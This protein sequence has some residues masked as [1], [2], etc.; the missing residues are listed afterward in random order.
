[1]TEY[2]STEYLRSHGLDSLGERDA[3]IALYLHKL[4]EDE[5]MI[6]MLLAAAA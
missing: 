6:L 1:M 5:H 4:M 2:V 3:E